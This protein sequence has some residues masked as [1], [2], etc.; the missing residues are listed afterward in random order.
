VDLPTPLWV[1]V[2]VRSDCG[3]SRN[4]DRGIVPAKSMFVGSDRTRS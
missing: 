1:V 2:F 4:N 3:C